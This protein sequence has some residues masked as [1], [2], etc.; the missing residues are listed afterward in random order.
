MEPLMTFRDALRVHLAAIQARDLD[1]FAATLPEDTMVLVT[2][3]GRL[4]RR[5]SEVLDMHAAWFANPHWT[6]DAA[7][8]HVEEGPGM[9]AALLRLDYR[10]TPPA[11]GAAVGQI[12][13]LTL[14]FRERGGRWVLVQDQNTPVRER[15]P[16]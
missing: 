9:G 2:S 16:A 15:Q 3:D 5:V 8:V 7:E 12:S 11:G 10:E 1:A 4:M 13:Y 6:L 14:I